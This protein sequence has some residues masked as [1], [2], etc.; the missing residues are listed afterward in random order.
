MAAM[1]NRFAYAYGIDL[2]QDKPVEAFKDAAKISDWAK[3]SVEYLTKAGILNGYPDGTF[4]P[5]G[6]ATRA[7]A[8]KIIST[9][10]GL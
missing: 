5:Q 6:N 9:F 8:A 4:Q 7:E 10:M 3:D 2:P 1:M